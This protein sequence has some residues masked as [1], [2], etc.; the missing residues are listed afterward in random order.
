M[1]SSMFAAAQVPH[2]GNILWPCPEAKCLR[3]L[4]AEAFDIL[5]WL[6]GVLPCTHP[7]RG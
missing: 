2:D 6:K 1:S 3:Y 4:M 5:L 7:M